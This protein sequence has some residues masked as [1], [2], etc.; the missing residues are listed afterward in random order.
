LHDGHVIPVSPEGISIGRAPE[1]GLVVETAEAS[2][3]HARVERTP[4][5]CVVVDLGSANGTLLNGERLEAESRLLRSGDTISIGEI[6]IRF[7][8]EETRTRTLTSAG[9]TE[10]GATARTTIGRDS[11][12]DIVLEAPTI[13]RFHAEVVYRDGSLEVRDL[14]SRNGTR[15]DGRVIDSAR[16]EVGSEIGVGPFR[17]VFDGTELHQ[18]DERG[19]VRMDAYDVTVQVK[20]KTILERASVS[21]Q[22]GELVVVIGES[23]SGKTS[24]MRVLAGVTRP[25]AG[26]VLVNGEP[27][28]TRLSDIGYLPQDEIV[29]PRLTVLES[30]RYSARLRLPHDSSDEEIENAVQGA[31]TETALGE[32]ASTRIGALSGGQ[33]KRVGL[34]TELLSS[35]GLLFLDEPTTGL[36]PGL[37]T[38]MME[39]F[40]RLASV[41]HRA[42][43]VVTHATRN[44]ELAD[45]LLVLGRG[46]LVC[47]SGPPR[48][49]LAFF[50]VETYDDIYLALE[51]RPADEWR[52]EFERH[53][54]G[55][56]AA[57][58]VGGASSGSRNRGARGHV[59]QARVLSARYARVFLRDRRNVL[60]LTA[61]TPLI[62]LAMALLFKPGVF[63]P[64]GRGIASSAAQLLFVL[65]V[66]TIWLGTISSAR[67]IIKERP[68]L[69]RE[70]A[71]GVGVTA[72]VFSKI[73]VLFPLAVA[74]AAVLLFVV[75]ALRPLHE[76]SSVVLSVFAL[77][78]LTG[79]AAVSMG[80]LISASVRTEE[81]AT[82]LIPI[83]MIAQLLF[84][85]AIVTIAEMGS[86]LGNLS[87]FMFS[88]WAF[89][90]VGSAMGMNDR[91]EG[92]DA[93]REV[94]TYGPDFFTLDPTGAFV[95]LGLF[96][97]ALLAPTVLV[98]GRR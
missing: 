45:R 12:N 77:L 50:G 92:D 62:A 93:F 65:V 73:A 19:T 57:Q 67:E 9:S 68:V 38:R 49:A 84:G 86:V 88:R 79:V 20:G 44:L 52:A 41:G 28:E 35:P 81:Q 34:A 24:L 91:I 8:S 78:A 10:R 63:E 55:N 15:L 46:G 11:A 48:E 54:G 85:G 58:P 51:A 95:A 33:R 87:A 60:I 66:T 70:R 2:R 83:S 94:S 47:F 74:Q 97:V 18:R 90:G 16:L 32:H 42:V 61:Q 26:V 56:V 72:Y 80:L 43:L 31:L 30:L 59:M 64:P 37:E 4:E 71:V 22:P 98:L 27:H 6:P 96:V 75:A 39:T 69:E 21:V 89:A 76:P 36:D 40:R 23:G 1:N 13:S 5:G 53:A 7:V 17:L 14:R 29:H 25:R 82:A 3:H